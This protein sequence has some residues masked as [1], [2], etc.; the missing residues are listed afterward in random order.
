MQYTQH[1]E[2]P[3]KFHF[4]C[5][6][7][8]IAGALRR[9]VWIDQA[10][11]RWLPN[12][13]VILVAPPG[14]VSKSTTASIG[15]DL[16]REVPD[17][18]FG[19]DSVTWQKLTEH[20]AASKEEVMMPDGLYHPMSC[21]TISS[22]ELGSFLK[23]DNP[24][25]IDVMVDLWDGKNGVWQKSTKTQGDDTIENPWINLIGCTTPAWIAGNF[26]DYMIGGGFTSRCIF[27]YAENKRK[28]VAY[29]RDHVPTNFEVE[30]SR[31][32]HDLKK[33]AELKGEFVLSDEAK[34]YGEW[35]YHEHYTNVPPHLDNERFSS[36]LARKQTHVHKLA[37]VLSA[38]RRDDLIIDA[39]ILEAA[40][41]I[42]TS[43]E[44]DM[45]RVFE[46]IGQNEQTKAVHDILSQ[47]HAH[48]EMRLA[49]LYNTL[50]R[51]VSFRDFQ[52][53]VKAAVYSK[54][55]KQKQEGNDLILSI[56]R[57]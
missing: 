19:P 9:R 25:M 7:S 27:I 37:M 55:V 13:Y 34:K 46:K 35:W 5:G 53:G 38:S 28:L 11:F 48:G 3:D 2:A 32:I 10:Y 39:E 49:D 4:W 14:V 29:P 21:V 18:N 22:S 26:P 17:I 54:Q 43:L 52:D 6:V 56:N 44:T 40:V 16:L 36:Y 8:T 24:E 47:I 45:P 41:D 20:M 57:G 23:P 12:F 30:R 51:R 50:S 42:I 33:I 1:S 15:M 31:L